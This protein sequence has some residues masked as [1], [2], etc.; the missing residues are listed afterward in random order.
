M[1]ISVAHA[2]ERPADFLCKMHKA[3]P[4][5][6]R[7]WL[8]RPFSFGFGFH[9][10]RP[11]LFGVITNHF[12]NPPDD[13]GLVRFG[14]YCHLSPVRHWH[15]DG[16]RLGRTHSKTL[17]TGASKRYLVFDPILVE[18]ELSLGIGY[19]KLSDT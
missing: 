14:R 9:C 19:L 11:H 8:I 7:R 5:R 15:W 16:V 10:R 1:Q 3:T 13:T 6:H 4:L 18:D 2:R 17:G 12:R